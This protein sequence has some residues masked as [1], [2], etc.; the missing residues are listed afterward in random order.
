[1]K[2][3]NIILAISVLA[4]T[5]VST[6]SCK[7]NIDD[8]DL[9]TFTGQMMIEHFIQRPDSFSNYLH[10]LKQ[11]H[12]SKRSE[13]TMYE[14]LGARGHYTCFAPT[15]EAVQH[16]LDSLYAIGE[17]NSAL[18][19]EVPD[20]IANFIVFNSLIDSGDKQDA[21]ATTDFS[22][23][24][25]NNNMNDRTMSV[26]YSNDAVSGMSN[27]YINKYSK[28]I[29]KDIKV[30]NGYI[31]VVDQVISPSNATVS[32]LIGATDN[33][34]FFSELLDVTGWGKKLLDFEDLDYRDN[35]KA[36][37]KYM[38]ADGNWEGLYPEHRYTKF[39][40]FVE[41]DSTF[42][43]NGI[44]NLE[45]LKQYI[46]NHGAAYDA[47]TSYDDDYTSENNAVNQFVAYH[48]VKVGLPWNRL[49]TWSNEWGYSNK[50]LNE[51]GSHKINVW[52]Y[53]E[54]M[55]KHRRS[56]KI[57]GTKREGL[58]INRKST[59]SEK[60]YAE[61]EVLIPGIEI[62]RFNDNYENTAL[63]G[64]YYPISDILLWTPEVPN[65]VLNERMRYDICSLLPELI[66]AGKRLNRENSWYF[67]PDF[68]ENIPS[69]DD[70]TD[71]EYLPNTNGSG[72][73]SAGWLDFQSDEFNIR[74]TYDFVIKLPPVP[75]N[76]TYEIRYGINANGNRGMA[77]IYLGTNPN[78]LPAVGIP[79][80][81]RIGGS[82]YGWK[83]DA[84]LGSAEA[85]DEF[86]KQLRNNN[87]M[88]GPKYFFP[89]EGEEARGFTNCLRRIIYTGTLYAGT[90]YYLRFKSVLDNSNSEFFFDYLEIVPKSVYNGTTAEDKW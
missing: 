26:D 47:N 6:N 77:Q 60:S 74:G 31:H 69:M 37:T 30:E 24:L 50:N 23:I 7:E 44:T 27:I 19:N 65:Q 2:L 42:E 86:D 54:T 84:S 78:N 14:L 51:N 1:M 8:S 17:L 83:N 64:Y 33:L 32:D 75:S 25:P 45:S 66:N 34:K 70:K 82:S 10:L 38:G 85:I 90:T 36:G 81:L 72:G 71:F 87:M 21:Y 39:T 57:T 53:W 11:V 4:A 20:S 52:E 68:F 56:L 13:S 63:N 73:G 18:V 28:I 40:I 3:K 46:I 59:Y 89:G 29:E 58:R 49:V 80:D 15:N 9:Y 5:C 79:L 12:P 55:G 62:H 61:L 76:G 35:E 67:T 48:L 16:Y 41:T 88:K 43:A 22:D